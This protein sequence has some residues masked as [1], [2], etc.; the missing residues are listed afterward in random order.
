MGHQENEE[1]ILEEADRCSATLGNGG[2]WK[3]PG[4]TPIRTAG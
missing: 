1:E 4:Q 2:T 3:I